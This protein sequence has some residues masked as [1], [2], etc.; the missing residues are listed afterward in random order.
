[1]TDPNPPVDWFP[2]LKTGPRVATH[3]TAAEVDLITAMLDDCWTGR[4]YLVGQARAVVRDLHIRIG[5]IE[6]LYDDPTK[7][8]QVPLLP[9]EAATLHNAY[10]AYR[11]DAGRHGANPNIIALFTG[12]DRRLGAYQIR[13]VTDE[14]HPLRADEIPALAE[15]ARDEEEF[16]HVVDDDT[17]PPQRKRR[18]PFNQGRTQN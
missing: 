11:E 12:L 13:R 9:E 5:A 18:W 14:A 6:E 17:E 16:G 1:V 7:P 3:I 15:R 4:A 10:G 2:G 8:L